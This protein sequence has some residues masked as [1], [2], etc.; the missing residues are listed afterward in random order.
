MWISTSDIKKGD[1][2]VIH[3]SGGIVDKV[4]SNVIQIHFLDGAKETWK[5]TA[6][7]QLRITDD[8]TI[9]RPEKTDYSG[10]IIFTSPP[11][12]EVNGCPITKNPCAEIGLGDWQLGVSIPEEEWKERY[13]PKCECGAEHTSYPT[14]HSR[15]CPKY[16]GLDF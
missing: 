15:W 5:L 4:G 12:M 1:L 7:D 3:K 10:K 9:T 6:I 14:T 2:I 16:N 11:I 8:C 13:N